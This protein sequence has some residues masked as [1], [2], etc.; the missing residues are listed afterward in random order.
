MILK[1]LFSAL[2]G[3]LLG[4]INTS[5]IVGKLLYKTDVRE[6]GSGNA[7]ATNTLRTLGKG[8][9]VAVVLGDLLKGIIACLLGRFL[10]GELTPGSGIYA[11][12]YLAG[13]FAVL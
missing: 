1:V 11:G 10:S 5:L 2:A 8:A 7:G 12:E 13:F 6:H 3:Y 4:S 9:A